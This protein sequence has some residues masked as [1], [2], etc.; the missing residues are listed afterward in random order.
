MLDSYH[1]TTLVTI[2]LPFIL[3][4]FFFCITSHLDVCCKK[5]ISDYII[6]CYFCREYMSITLK[7]KRS[8]YSSKINSLIW[9]WPFPQL[10]IVFIFLS[11]LYSFFILNSNFSKDAYKHTPS[12]FK[13]IYI[14][15][16]G[17]D[18]NVKLM[19]HDSARK[20][21]IISAINC[22]NICI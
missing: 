4:D 13:Y 15:S 1:F 18:Y 19:A 3:P 21:Q 22:L 12:V 5:G 14:S 11:D 2:Y 8:K 16:L 17:N 9:F 7:K 20:M 10:L 6:I